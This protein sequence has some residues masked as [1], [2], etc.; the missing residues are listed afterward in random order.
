MFLISEMD[1]RNAHRGEKLTR[2]QSMS[3]D[4]FINLHMRKYSNKTIEDILKTPMGEDMFARFVKRSALTG[5]LESLYGKL[6]FCKR[7][8]ND[9]NLVRCYGV[10]RDINNYRN[11]YYKNKLEEAIH[12]FLDFKEV[13]LAH[14]F[15]QWKRELI[16]RL[17]RSIDRIHFYNELRNRGSTILAALGDIYDDTFGDKSIDIYR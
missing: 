17:N 4:E 13:N 5:E 15:K 8:V 7:I 3:K 1:R 11:P 16:D 2:G 10:V 9:L 12:E 14:Y 6:K